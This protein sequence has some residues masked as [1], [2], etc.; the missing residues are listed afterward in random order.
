MS[1]N[2]KILII[3]DDRIISFTLKKYFE[4]KKYDVDCAYD[5]LK[6][7]EKIKNDS[8]N[9][10]ILDINLPTISGF[11]VAKKLKAS[12]VFNEIP[13]IFL[14]SLVQENNIKQGYDI[15]A[16]EYITKPVSIEYLCSRVEKHIHKIAV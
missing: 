14:S 4:S 15:G 13:I 8:P 3:E 5:G 11:D 2:N 6:G 10:I 16:E 12:D 9:L 1:E 7:L